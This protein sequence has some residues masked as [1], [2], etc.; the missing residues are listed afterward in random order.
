[1]QL[2]VV[3]KHLKKY[4]P[5]WQV[6]VLCGRGK[7][8][9][10]G[11]LCHQ[12]YYEQAQVNGVH[13]DQ[14]IDLY[15]WE[16]YNAYTD[17][18][19]SK[20]T[21]C[22]REVFGLD[23]D[24]SLAEYHVDVSEEDRRVARTYLRSI[25][26]KMT[27]RKFNAVLLHYQGNTSPEK[28]NLDH[29]QAEGIVR[30]ILRAGRVPVLLD[31]DRRSGLPDQRTVFN[32]GI[33]PDDIWGDIGTGDASRIAALV[34]VAEAFV[35]VD[36]GPGKVASAVPGTPALIVWL[37]HLPIQFHDPAR[38]TTHL[39]PVTYQ[40]IPPCSG[41]PAIVHY[42]MQKYQCRTYASQDNLVGEVAIWLSE[43]LKGSEVIV[44]HKDGMAY[45]YGFWFPEDNP[46]Q[47]ITIINDI[48]FGDAYRTC[49]RGNTKDVEYVVDIGANIGTFSKLWYERN[50]QA[51][52]AAVEVNRKLLP[53]LQA[54]VGGYAAII[55]RACHYGSG[56][57]LL[58]SVFPEGLSIGGSRVVEQA[59]FDAEKDVVQYLHSTEP[60]E[61]ITLEEVCRQV[62]FPWIDFLKLDCEGSELSILEHCDLSKV[63]TI[64]V[65]SHDPL[66]WRDLL[67]RR[68]EGWDVGHMF[69]G[70]NCEIWH[71]V[72]P[73]GPR[74]E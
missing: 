68:F 39:I 65:E 10:L 11:S 74:K 33:G 29:R 25:G 42:M 45:Q 36:S 26:C 9:A 35:G 50:P 3:L 62:D 18:P 4:R 58:D 66:R 24:E 67:A 1:M 47:A 51:R 7:H 27:E 37:R 15:W 56:L 59:E 40:E 5:N 8:G 54:N 32:P 44:M 70:G 48:Y 12:V 43:K 6:D 52:I 31:W 53:A 64:F 13:Y 34:E 72:N 30:W 63:G 49:L 46:Q 69:V 16:N 60:V 19:N 21:N 38:A 73:K 14:A 20:I 55:A 57:R 17:K 2:S 41:K 23:W 28:K 71:L 22:L 61:T